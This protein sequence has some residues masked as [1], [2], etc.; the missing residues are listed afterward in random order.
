[1]LLHPG[2]KFGPYVS[3]GSTT[4]SGALGV[5][6]SEG[7]GQI[8]LELALER[9]AKRETKAAA[10][11][12]WKEKKVKGK[13]SAKPAA[14]AASDP[15]ASAPAAAAAP[16]KK[17]AGKVSIREFALRGTATPGENLDKS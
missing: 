4:A 6:E 7:L 16:R 1:M 15:L 3:H 17:V 9:L 11:S 8:G 10:G 14:P 12:P 13:A 5:P 2:G